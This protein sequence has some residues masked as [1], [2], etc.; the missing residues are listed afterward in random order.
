MATH[1]YY[2]QLGIDAGQAVKAFSDT[3]KTADG[4][5]SSL[6]A[7]HGALEQVQATSDSTAEKAGRSLPLYKKLADAVN[8][9][10]RASKTLADPNVIKGQ[11]QVSATLTSMRK[12]LESIG[13][14]EGLGDKDKLAQISKT[15]ELYKQLAQAARTYSASL[16]E[17]ATAIKAVADAESRRLQVSQAA[18]NAKTRG[19]DAWGVTKEERALRT[20]YQTVLQAEKEMEAEFKRRREE[21][22]KLGTTQLKAQRENIR[23]SEQGIRQSYANATAE[24]RLAMS[25]RTANQQREN[26]IAQQGQYEQ[27]L[28][29]TRYA[30]YEVA[31]TYTAVATAAAALPVASTK[32]AIEMEAQF[33]HV[34]RTT[35]ATG[36]PLE[37]LRNDFVNLS[38]EIPVT[39]EELSKIGTLGA[40]MDIPVQSLESFSD[41]VAKFSATTDVSVDQAAMSFG[42]LANM[43]Q[44]TEADYRQLGASISELGTASVATESEILAIAESIATTANMAGFAEHEVVGLSTAMASL[45][46][47]PEMARGAL[48]RIFAQINA[49]VAD[50]SETLTSYAAAL[51]TTEE[52]AANLWRNDPS[53]FF[54]RVAEAIGQ[55]DDNIARSQFIREGL[56]L[57]NV[58]DVELLNRLA[59][60]YEVYADSMN[61]AA[62]AYAR[63]DYLEKE[64][65]VIFETTAAALERLGSAFKGMLDSFGGDG[66]GLL[67]GAIELLINLLNAIRD[68]P[69][70]AKNS[71]LALAGLVAVFAGLR[72]G[73]ALT[74]ASMRAFRM[75]QRH[76]G[77]EGAVSLATLRRE[78][79]LT[80][81]QM[82]AGLA[83]VS[84]YFK[85]VR[86][87]M[88]DA[89]G[90]MAKTRVAA[91]GLRGAL[92]GIGAGGW[93]G[94]ILTGATA[95]T[96]LAMSHESA[97]QKA[98]QHAEAL[99]QS[100]GGAEKV[101][102]A[103]AKD[104][105]ELASGVQAEPIAELTRELH[106]QAY[107]FEETASRSSIYVHTMGEVQIGTENATT[108]IKDQTIAIGE[109]TDALIRNALTEFTP[110]DSVNMDAINEAMERGFDFDRW[111]NL[112]YT[113]GQEGAQ[114]YV[115]GFNAK[116]WGEQAWHQDFFDSL[117]D[118]TD[119]L[120]ESVYGA[121]V[122]GEVLGTMAQSLGVDLEE[123]GEGA[124]EGSEGV[125]TLADSFDNLIT[126]MFGLIDAEAGV[127]AALDRLGAAIDK[128]GESFD[129]TTEAGR[130]N[131]E[132]LRGVIDAVAKDISAQVEAG[133]MTAA[134]GAEAFAGYVD[135][136]MAEL[137]Q[138]GVDTSQFDSFRQ[139]LDSLF[140]NPVVVGVDTEPAINALAGLQEYAQG[141]FEELHAQGLSKGM[142]A[143]GARYSAQAYAA[144]VGDD[145]RLAAHQRQIA[146]SRARAAAN[147][148]RRQA[149][150][151]QS[152][153]DGGAAA[154][155]ARAEQERLNKELDKGNKTTRDT[156]DQAKRL[157]EEIKNASDEGRIFEETM[158]EL[159]SAFKET[160]DRFGGHQAAR[161]SMEGHLIAM[162]KAA[163]D[164]KEEVKNLREEA[165][166][167]RREAK[168]LQIEA[169]QADIFAAVARRY[170][171][172]TRYEEYRN[173]AKNARA[174]AK[175]KL[176]LAKTAEREAAALDKNRLALTGYS[177]Q[178]IK[179]RDMVR[180]LQNEM[181]DL[182]L[183][184]AETGATTEEVT[185]YA[186]GLR[187]KFVDQLT[188]MGYNKEEVKRLS[189]VFIDLKKDIERVPREVRVRAKADVAE[190]KRKLKDLE[191]GR[192]VP[193]TVRATNK[194]LT[195]PGTL[196]AQKGNIR[197]E[198][199]ANEVKARNNF[200]YGYG[201]TSNWR[202]AGGGPIP[203]TYSGP[204]NKDDK[205]VVGPNGPEGSIRSAEWVMP[206]ESRR[207]YG[208]DFMR[209]VQTMRYNPTVHVSAP[210]SSVQA[211]EL[212][213]HQINQL[214]RAVSTVLAVDG[215]AIAATT[216][217]QNARMSRRGV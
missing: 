18:A 148:A 93:I 97:A 205:L 166:K 181:A 216:N 132:A 16:R 72:A 42:R 153:Y 88:R 193:V 197:G 108:A 79:A 139:H 40:Q 152:R 119:A 47:R 136:L 62:D 185:R 35:Q 46:I 144:G 213:P 118:Y 39:F 1:E 3:A 179:N 174:S 65:G 28:A 87:D 126:Q 180:Q 26:A 57:R 171:D 140:S 60:G 6:T 54:Q 58:R 203:G 69:Q 64:A 2:A 25:I 133:N 201:I 37:R 149:E 17:E 63:G 135:G 22:Q 101:F 156:A 199:S 78:A 143:S 59:N 98:R 80:F 10:G 172:D 194:S 5:T 196:E 198:L 34:A 82:S 189:R 43:M 29:A 90:V 202:R 81:P 56:G 120:G 9:Y 51:G 74:M 55:L 113:Q 7:L 8:A 178:A 114:K 38:T 52:A 115:E 99:Q 137:A 86:K 44:L 127:Y 154:A 107:Q 184:Y 164:A 11:Q 186:E 102:A 20:Q 175:E 169:N 159:S 92:A 191:K 109:H 24:E 192:T 21:Q 67:K 89:T 212:L 15:L 141:V 161:D 84:A 160:L 27:G 77:V 76:I 170:G 217:T 200:E 103:L 83:T 100:M 96:T 106:G 30:L 85:M 61:L 4:L 105:E 155:R 209:A 123:M 147:E 121:V 165:G 45:R 134:A 33:A 68:M 71:A 32:A 104:A 111:L 145:G 142:A 31:A 177:E 167:L 13:K 23:L 195:I 41:T 208:D 173:E 53:Q 183:K 157:R 210:S 129:I 128:N 73:M 49:A 187:R 50:G 182:I 151:Y 112:L 204:L 91:H 124:E 48:Q 94:I 168:D 158:K 75:V 14:A 130:N 162:R 131:M 190:A 110:P 66:S 116:Q 12:E 122:H 163:Q 211:V 36:A 188:Q 138:M 215:K 206:V 150:Q 207:H 176:G 95:L 125:D 70:W 19:V 117:N 214:A 146:R